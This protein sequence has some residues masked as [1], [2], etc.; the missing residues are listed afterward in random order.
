MSPATKLV[1]ASVTS[2]QLDEIARHCD[3]PEAA[4]ASLARLGLIAGRAPDAT[5]PALWSTVWAKPDS[6]GNWR[7]EAP[8]CVPC[9]DGLCR[10]E[11]AML[12]MLDDTFETVG[13]RVRG[14]AV[15]GLPATLA[16]RADV[17]RCLNRA[18]ERVVGAVLDTDVPDSRLPRYGVTEWP[19]PSRIMRRLAR[20]SAHQVRPAGDDIAHVWDV[21]PETDDDGSHLRA[22]YDAAMGDGPWR[23][24][25]RPA[26]A[27]WA[28]ATE[29]ALRM[30]DHTAHYDGI[31]L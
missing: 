18:I 12:M 11:P 22:P 1:V 17:D 4:K 21:E 23:P 10:P 28:A 9:P 5:G 2:D 7:S 19:A 16:T 30:G 3:D 14:V 27:T 31:G 20:M 15:Q 6:T 24:D 29:A 26:Q 8:G 25:M 13:V